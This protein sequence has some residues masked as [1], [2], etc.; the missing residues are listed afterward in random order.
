M[1]KISF[2][3]LLCFLSLITFSQRTLKLNDFI[4]ESVNS[5]ESSKKA[6]Y[7]IINKNENDLFNKGFLP[8]LA[9]NFTFP[10][11]NRSISEVAQPDG[12]FAFK[13]SNSANSRV[14]LSLS[15]KIPFTGGKLTISNSFNRLDLFGDTQNSTSYSAS[16]FGINL[17]QPLNFFN[18]MKW[19]KKIQDAKFE[20]NTII[21]IK[22]GIGIKKKALKHYFELLKIKNEEKLVTK[23]IDVTNKYKKHV[24]S[25]IKAGRI[26]A[27][28]S[29]DI[30]LKLLNEQK[31]LRFLNKSEGLKIQSIN[32]FFNNEIF[33]K[34]DSLIIPVL[35]VKLEELD[36]Y[37]KKYT[38]LYYIVMRNN[39][40]S[41]EKNIKQLEKSRFYAAN[42]SLGVGFNN[43]ADKYR[44]IFQ[45]PNESQNFS[46]SL[47]VPVLDF[48]KKRIELEVVRNQYDIEIL[49][50][51]QEKTFNIERI[52]FLYEEINDLLYSLAIEKSRTELLKVKL[53][54]MEM[55]LYAQ[56]ILFQD[57]SETEDLL[58]R[59]LSEKVNI[60]QNIYNKIIELEEITLIEI[61][62]NEN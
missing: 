22:N 10:T 55:L 24:V 56:K 29:I 43:S 41:Y 15:Q 51:E 40:L 36:F 13:E 33:N 7:I 21:N 31:N 34:L 5:I 11:Y 19:D 32:A 37:I 3:G 20:Y 14:N 47:N 44:Y 54:R 49:N 25:L 17:S 38:D 26:M 4:E 42:L 58:F 28:D 23:R 59:S 9:L 53:S 30:E 1:L 18:A 39:L 35:D 52:S 2:T 50:L 57:Y 6:K 61:I 8:D 16:W 62:K 12:T 45:N 48:G 60:T 27:Y 46:I